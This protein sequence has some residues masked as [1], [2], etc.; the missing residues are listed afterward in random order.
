MKQRNI[1]YTT[2]SI[3]ITKPPSLSLT[4]YDLG[5]WNWTRDESENKQ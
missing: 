3:F 4:S 5:S 2:S 1:D